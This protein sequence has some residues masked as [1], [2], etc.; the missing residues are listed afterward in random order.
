MSIGKPQGQ[1][2][3]QAPVSSG[4]KNDQL[5]LMLYALGGALKRNKKKKRKTIKTF[6][7]R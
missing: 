7:Q 3:R 5:G 4:G 2:Q 1:Q 6:F